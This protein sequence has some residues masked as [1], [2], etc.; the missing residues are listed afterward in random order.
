MFINFG[1]IICDYGRDFFGTYL[2]ITKIVRI[3][4]TK[5]EMGKSCNRNTHTTS[6]IINIESG[7]EQGH[8]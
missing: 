2:Y 6:R 8:G 3:I 4:I 1:S 7:N 5:S